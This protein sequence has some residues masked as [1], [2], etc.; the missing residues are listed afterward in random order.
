MWRCGLEV[1]WE[2]VWEG[3]HKFINYLLSLTEIKRLMGCF[4][5]CH[6]GL[7]NSPYADLLDPI[8]W[9]EAADMFAQSAC[10]L[11]GLPLESSLAVR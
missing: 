10:K 4:L 11:M 8:H 2:S 3:L 9:T 7:D 6:K 1:E 5:Y